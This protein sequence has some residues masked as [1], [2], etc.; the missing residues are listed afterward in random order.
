L[1]AK[2]LANSHFLTQFIISSGTTLHR[3]L[4]LVNSK[5]M[6]LFKVFHR[7]V[8]VLTC[9]YT[10]STGTSVNREIF[11]FFSSGK[12]PPKL[13]AFCALFSFDCRRKGADRG[14]SH[15]KRAQKCRA[16]KCGAFDRRRQKKYN[17]LFAKYIPLYGRS[18]KKMPLMILETRDHHEA[19]LSA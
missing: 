3:K 4:P 10:F 6:F 11:L 18:Y 15:P 16:L 13:A 5:H 7:K 8:R 17:S 1:T 2:L 14:A 19:D 9:F 12:K